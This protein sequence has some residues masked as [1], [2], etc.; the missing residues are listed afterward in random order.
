[1]P[2]RPNPSLSASSQAIKYKGLISFTSLYREWAIWRSAFLLTFWQ[3]IRRLL[4]TALHRVTQ[5]GAAKRTG[6]ARDARQGCL[7]RRRR[8]RKS[9]GWARRGRSRLR[10]S[11][12]AVPASSDRARSES[13]ISESSYLLHRAGVLFRPE[14]V[15]G[16]RLFRVAPI[17]T[18]NLFEA[19]HRLRSTESFVGVLC[20]PIA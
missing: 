9:H 6:S 11:D 16:E 18:R 5:N 1:M 20:K 7:V 8:S 2:E 3:E 19:L 12:P 10:G 13:R 15:E 14:V 17:F 4:S